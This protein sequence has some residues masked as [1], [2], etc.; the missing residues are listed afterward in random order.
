MKKT[1]TL[2]AHRWIWS[3]RGLRREILAHEAALKALCGRRDA[4]QALTLTLAQEAD[5]VEADIADRIVGPGSGA[6]PLWTS[7]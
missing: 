1:D 4:A 5:A 2:T 3:L 6:E 7:T